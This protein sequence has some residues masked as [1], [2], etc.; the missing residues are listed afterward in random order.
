VSPRDYDAYLAA[1]QAGQSTAQAL[2][3]I[4]QPGTATTTH[5]FDLLHDTQRAQNNASGGNGGSLGNG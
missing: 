3:S 1:R 2:E 5:P 4:G